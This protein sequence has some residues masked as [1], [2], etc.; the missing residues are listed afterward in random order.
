MKNIARLSLVLS[1]LFLFVTSNESNA[2]IQSQQA[3]QQTNFNNSYLPDYTV[4]TIDSEEA[5]VQLAR[6]WGR[7]RRKHVCLHP[8]TRSKNSRFMKYCTAYKIKKARKARAHAKARIL[9]QKAFRAKKIARMPQRGPQ[10]GA[11]GKARGMRGNGSTAKASPLCK[12]NPQHLN[13]R[14]LKTRE[15]RCN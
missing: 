15:K 6:K 5:P 2:S 3:S 7:N 13:K 14:A 10:T 9:K 4:N 12:I 1:V 8:S 11:P